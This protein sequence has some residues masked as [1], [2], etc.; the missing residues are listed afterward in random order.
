M[1]AMAAPGVPTTDPIEYIVHG[2]EER[3]LEY[4]SSFEWRSKHVQPV[5]G[6]V[7]AT[8]LAMAN[9]R[10]GGAIVIGMAECGANRWAPEGVRP[11]HLGSWRQDVVQAKANAYADPHVDMA[12]DLVDHAGERFVVVQVAPFGDVPVICRTLLTCQDQPV[13]QAGAIYTRPHRMHETAQVPNHGEMREIVDRAVDV[14]L[15]RLA[16]RGLLHTATERPAT[17]RARFDDELGGI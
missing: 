15:A 8:I 6:K 17:D 3:W 14:Q 13:L 2:R 16:A 9:L 10:D 7:L 5:Q 12:L 1:L 11:E 4:K